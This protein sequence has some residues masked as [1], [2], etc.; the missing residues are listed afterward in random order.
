MAIFN[1]NL[2]VYRRVPPWRAGKLNLSGRKSP[3]RPLRRR[4]PTPIPARRCL[5]QDGKGALIPR[6]NGGFHGLSWVLIAEK[7]W[8]SWWLMRFFWDVD[9]RKWKKHLYPTDSESIRGS[10][11][12]FIHYTWRIR[13]GGCLALNELWWI[14]GDGDFRTDTNQVRYKH[15][16]FAGW[17]MC[18]NICQHA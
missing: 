18:F 4:T 8:I 2:L 12:I 17:E 6:K 1:S 7:W 11:I 13:G 10:W 3:P 5:S 16:H 9:R 15:Q 14:H